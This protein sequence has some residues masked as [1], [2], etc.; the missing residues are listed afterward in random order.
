MRSGGVLELASDVP[1]H[2]FVYP[3]DWM[4]GNVGQDVTQIGFG[5]DVVEFA[6]LDERIHGRK[7]LRC[8]G[9]SL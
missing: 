7:P 6:R 9:R 3:I 2:E 1:R 4:V 8:P 5:I